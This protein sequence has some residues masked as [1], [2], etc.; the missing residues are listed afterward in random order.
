MA[1]Q[2]ILVIKLGALGDVVQA[3]GPFA[4]IRAHHAGAHITLLTGKAYADFLGASDWFDEVW[5]DERPG[6][7]NWRAWFRLRHRIKR[8]RFDR[9]YD[10]QTSDRSSGYFHILLPGPRPEWSGIARFASHPHAN[11]KR[12]D[13][14]TVDRQAEQLAMAGVA[15]VPSPDLDWVAADISRYGLE[16]PYV[17]LVPGGSAHRP[18]KRWPVGR[19]TELARRLVARGVTPVLIGAGPDAHATGT[20]AS[21]CEGAVDL[22]ADTSFAEIVALARG[23]AGAV[24]NDTGPMHAIATAGCPSV[25]LYSF[26]SDPALCAQKGPDVTIIRKDRLDDVSVDE[27]EAALKLD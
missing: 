16:A 1:A 22:T 27:V 23:A 4:A 24:G 5:I 17:L 2:R 12:D 14:H 13:M 18:E 15:E 11:P 3:T 20:V 8:G 26:A 9:V 6:W 10:L 21:F 7:K 19:Y 25:A